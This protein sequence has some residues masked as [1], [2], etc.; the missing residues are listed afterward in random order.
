VY[1][2]SEL[3]AVY[4]QGF[5]HAQDRLW[6]I[7]KLRKLSSG[8]MSEILGK[9][10]LGI[11]KFYRTIG[12]RQIAKDSL[13][14]IDNV[15]KDILNAYS[16]GIND[17][18]T[19]IKFMQPNATAQ[20]LPPEF[21]L[22]NYTTIEPWSP[23]DTLAIIKLLNFH[24]SWNWNQDLLREVLEKEGLADMVEEIFPFTAEFS[25]NLVT[26]LD[27]DDIKDT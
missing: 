14:N 3:M 22:F 19:N 12:I 24:L 23:V 9:N 8:R 10:A 1:A 18:L 13:V 20:L 15:Q 16:N 21:Y 26:I 11:D 2:S 4:S 17:F 27:A 7:E 25:Y 5:L 6:Q